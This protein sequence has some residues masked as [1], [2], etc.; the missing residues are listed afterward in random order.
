MSNCL[1]HFVGFILESSVLYLIT[2]VLGLLGKQ[3]H[4]PG[5]GKEGSVNREFFRLKT[6]AVLKKSLEARA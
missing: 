3:F 4:N 6:R 1:L 2:I 5:F